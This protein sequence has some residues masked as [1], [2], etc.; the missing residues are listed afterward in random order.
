MTDWQELS[1]AYG[2]AGDVPALLARIDAER[3]PELWSELWSAL[4]HQGSVYSAS[5][6]ALPWLADTAAVDDREQA[7]QALYLAGAVLAG[8]GQAHGAG[9][10]R[11]RYASEIATLL[12]LVNRHLRT[13]T[14]GSEYIDL[15]ESMLGIEGV[16]GW[17]EELAWGL[18]N[19]EYEIACPGCESD[20]F[21]VLAE[22]GFFTSSGEYSLP[23]TDA[24]TTRPL[25]PAAPAALDGIGR[26]LH[27]LALSDGRSEV[28][29][30]L[31][32]VFGAA[33]CP[34]CDTDFAVPDR[35]V[36]DLLP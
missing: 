8:T 10:V 21:V 1:H 4:C 27:D 15:L 13:A 28:A 34:D 11:A 30:L 32:Y 23:D 19:E 31:T 20:L 5:F 22:G 2:P 24:A 3:D 25:R 36:S 17:G 26:R 6:A 18:G 12:T 9:D 33:T 35:I 29:H 14:G 16:P 7:V